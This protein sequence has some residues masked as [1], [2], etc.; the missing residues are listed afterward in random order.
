MVDTVLQ[1][2]YVVGAPI[3]F[4]VGRTIPYSV[5]GR[6]RRQRMY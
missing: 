5:V 4:D 3:A 2:I 6:C 1:S